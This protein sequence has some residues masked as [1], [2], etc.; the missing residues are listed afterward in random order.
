VIVDQTGAPVL[1]MRE[2]PRTYVL[3]DPDLLNTQG[4]KTLNGAKTAVALLDLIRA[5]DTPVIFDLTQHGFTRPRSLL[6]LALEPPLL[7]ATLVLLA[8]AILA[9]IQAAVRFGPARRGA[10]PWPWERPPWPTT[11]PA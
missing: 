10:A 11:P 4:L 2:E 3:A 7:G 1:V 9:G 5:R 6:R 8:L